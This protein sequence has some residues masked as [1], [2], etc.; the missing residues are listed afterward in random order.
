M[1]YE[2]F[3][4]QI[5]KSGLTL[6]DFAELLHLNKNSLSNL[7]GKEKVP[8]HLAVIVVLLGEMA[9]HKIDFRSVIE[10]I[11]LKKNEPR[12]KGFTN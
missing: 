5:G 1:D 11:D 9:E 6:K 3:K 10:R 12:G 2:E 4:R 7:A 8:D